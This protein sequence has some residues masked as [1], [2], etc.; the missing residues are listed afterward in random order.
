MSCDHELANEWACCSGKKASCIAIVIIVIG[1][2]KA[3]YSGSN[4][5]VK[6]GRVHTTKPTWNCKHDYSLNCTTQYL[7]TN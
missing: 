6:R 2:S 1:P 5:W 4:A 7:I 3:L